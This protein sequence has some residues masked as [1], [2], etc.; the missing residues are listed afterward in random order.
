MNYQVRMLLTL[1]VVL[2]VSIGLSNAV[3]NDYLAVSGQPKIT[4]TEKIYSG[5]PYAAEVKLVRVGI[6]PREATLNVSTGSVNPIIKLKVDGG[7]EQTYTS[8]SVILPLPPDGV[9]E[10]EVK[11]SGNAPTVTTDRE[12]E[13]F[14]ISTYVVYD[15]MNKGD[16][17]EIERSL[18]VTN[19]EIEDALRSIAEAKSRLMEAETAISD[20]KSQNIDTTSLE[21]RLEIAR[22]TIR[23][24]ELSKE[25]GYPIEAKRQ[26]D[27]AVKSLEGIIQDASARSKTVYDIKKYA[28]IAVAVI[29]AIIGISVLRR[30]RE[31]LG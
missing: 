16:Q 3:E 31:E 14:S 18:K 12:V 13:M 8:Q 2:L 7:D 6:I 26:A 10:I 30:K 15:D 5:D 22:D 1:S 11:I 29:V 17:L 19:P 21:S 25:R 9:S 4:H 24:A 20:L 23:D 28:A 27:N